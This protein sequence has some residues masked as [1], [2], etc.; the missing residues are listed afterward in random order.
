MRRTNEKINEYNFQQRKNYRESIS[1]DKDNLSK[2]NDSNVSSNYRS[3]RSTA[4]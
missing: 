4:L 1:K 2:I 3:N